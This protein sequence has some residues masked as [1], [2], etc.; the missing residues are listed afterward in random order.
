MEKQKKIEIKKSCLFRPFEG[1]VGGADAVCEE[2]CANI[3]MTGS[4]CYIITYPNFAS[5]TAKSFFETIKRYGNI[6]S[7]EYNP[8]E[9]KQ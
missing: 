5:A 6:Y 1:R 4:G 2:F 7:V 9:D 3:S 8:K